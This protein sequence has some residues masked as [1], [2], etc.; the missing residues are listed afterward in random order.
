MAG[1]TTSTVELVKESDDTYS[2]N[3]TS[4]FR[5]QQVKFQPGVEFTEK[6]MD[7]QDVPC[8]ITFEGNK[9]IQEQKGDKPVTLVRTFT[10][11]ELFLT[12][13]TGDVEAKRWFKAC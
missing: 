8:V 4:T 1:S 13:K 3:T 12:C 11:E 10:D 7:G 6:R 2:F 5:S 9:M